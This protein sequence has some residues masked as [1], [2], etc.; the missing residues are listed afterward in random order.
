LEKKDLFEIWRAQKPP[1][2]A[3]I[4]SH[5]PVDLAEKVH[6]AQAL[7]GPKLFIALAVCPTGWGVDPELSEAIAHLAGQPGV[8]PLKEA[9][10]GTVRHTYI[11][12]R[13]HHVSE[14]LEP[15]RR[16]RHLFRPHRQDDRLGA[17]QT[18]VDSY[19]QQVR[20]TELGSVESNP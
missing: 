15:Q 20:K 1:Y 8:W 2:L 19:W 3:T 5:E 11:P 4:T 16:F 17:I 12:E 9:V 7:A 18:R 13:L 14:Y 6:R 10:G